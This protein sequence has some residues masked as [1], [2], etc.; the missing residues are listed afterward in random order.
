MRKQ[1]RS[2]QWS[3]FGAGALVIVALAW[4]FSSSASHPHFTPGR[5]EA[6]PTS[7]AILTSTRQP[8]PQTQNVSADEKTPE[9]APSETPLDPVFAAFEEWTE[10]YAAAPAD[11]KA[12]LEAAGVTLSA[13]RRDALL[14]LM[15]ADPRRAL[16]KSAPYRTRNLVPQSVLAKLEIPIHAKGTLG[17]AV[18]LQFDNIQHRRSMATINDTI[19]NAHLYGRRV[20][21]IANTPIPLHGIAIGNDVAIH[22]NPVRLL[23]A[24]EAAAVLAAN[25]TKRFCPISGREV[26][27]DDAAVA[28]SG[29]EYVYL[30]H[31]NH[32]NQLN[33]QT[34]A[35]EGGADATGS[36]PIAQSAWTT[37]TKTLLY[38]I[39]RFSDQ[40]AE[41]QSF[42]DATN[43]MNTVSAWF[44]EVSYGLTSMTPTITPCFVLPNDTAYYNTNGDGVLMSDARAVAK[45]NGFDYA[46]YNLD[47]IRWNGGPGSYG[48][49]AYVG[50]RGCWLKS[51][52][53]GVAEH[54]FGH[55]YGLWHANYWN[56]PNDTVIGPGSNVEYGDPFDVMG[57]A[58][59][60]AQHYNAYE[61]NRLDWIPIANV[62]TVTTN[63]TYRLHSFDSTFNAANQFAIKTKKDATRDYWVDFRQK[64]TSNKWQ[65]NGV[66]LHW[67]P[68]SASSGSLLLDTTPSSPDGKNDSGI[69]LGRTFSDYIADVHITPIGKGGTTPES[70]DV[71]INRGTWATDHVPTLS[72]SASS[73][74]VTTG[75]AVN[76]TAT[77]SDPD[78]DTLS[79]YWEFG[80]GNFGTNSPSASKSWG[81]AREYVVRCTASDMKG[82]TASAQVVI[83][84]GA[85]TVRRIT[86]TVRDSLGNPLADVRVHNGLATTDS[87][88]RFCFTATDGT[89]SLVSVA[90][91]AYTIAAIKPG[92]TFA[93][94]FT[95]P[96][97]GPATGIDF[98]A[99]EATYKITGK[100]TTD[101][102][103]ALGAALVSNGTVTEPTD[104]SGNFTLPGIK[105]GAYTLTATKPGYTLT[106][107]GFTNPVG[108]EYGDATAKNFTG[109][110]TTY[111]ISGEITGVPAGSAVTVTDGYR[112]TTSYKN[113]AKTLYNLFGVP[114]GTWTLRA[115]F[116]GTSFTP[117]NFTNPLTISASVTNKNFAADGTQAFAISGTVTDMGSPLSGVTVSSGTN[118]GTTDTNGQYFIAGLANGSYTLT[119]TKSGFS[120]TPA[121]RNI[122]VASANITGQNFATTNVDTPPT[123]ATAAS[124]TPNPVL[125]TTTNLSVLGAD[126]NGEAYLTYTWSTVGTPPGPVTFNIN[127]AHSARNAVATFTAGAYG[128]YTLR[129]TIK[130]YNGGTVTS[131]VN[132]N[133]IDPSSMPQVAFNAASSSGSESVTSVS[134][135]VS[136]SFASAQTVTVNYAVS[137]GSATGGGTDYTLASG[138]LSFAAGVTSK[139]ISFS[140]VNDALD[141][142]NETIQITLSSPTNSVLGANSNHT[143]TITDD[144]PTPTVAF[145]AANSSGAESATPTLLPV[146]LSAASGQTI[147]VNYAVTGGTATG[148]GTD[149]TLASGTLTFNAGTTTQNISLAVVNDALN[150]ADETVQ[151]TL[152]SPANATLG[153]NTVHTYTITD[154]DPQ[155]TVAFNAASSSGS[156]SVTAVTL[157][158]SLSAA[159]GR[160]VT[161]NYAVTGGTATGGGVDYTLASGTLTFNAGTT[162]QNISVA[163]VNDTAS[164]PSETI[165]VTL[166]SPSNATLGTNTVHTY[167]I[168]DNDT[169]VSFGAASSSGAESATAVN[170]PVSLS[171]ASS[172]T[173]SVNYA[174]TGGT[175]TG[176][177]TD[178]TLASGTLTFAPGTT[179]QN[180]ALSVNDDALNEANETVQI[181]LSSPVNASLG[182][183]SVHTYTIT[184]NDPAPNVAFNA[185]SSSGLENITAVSIPVSLN[186]ASGQSVTVA[187]A[188]TGGTATGGGVDYTLASGTLT[189]NAGTTT[190]NISVT[191]VNDTASEPSETIQI[192]LSSPTNATLGTNTVYTYTILDNDTTVAFGT[193][194]SSGSESA[195]AVNIPV[196]LSNA[197]SQTISVNYAVTGGTATGSGTDYTLASGTLTFAPGTATQNIA[198]AVVNDAL[199]ENDETI[200]L[201]L[202]S[203]TNAAL[204]AI[205]V[206]TY[207]ITDN[208]PTP[209]VGF[210][211]ASSSGLEN[212][213]AVNIP[214]SLSAAS[215]LSVSVAYAV[216]GGSATGGGTDY[217]LA[218]GTLTFAAGT[219]S[220]NI[221]VTIVNDAAVEPIETIQITLSAPVNATLGTATHIYSILND[222]NTAPVATNASFTTSKNVAVSG[223]LA[224]TDAEN[225]PLTFSIVANGALGTAVITNAATGAFTYTPKTGVR[226]TD[227][228]TF[229]ANDG[230]L[231]SNTA[232]VTVKINNGKPVASASQI[233]AISAAPASGSFTASD[234]DSDPLTYTVLSSGTLGTL[235][236][237]PATGAFT[238]T[239]QNNSGGEDQITFQVTDGQDVSNTATLTIKIPPPITFGSGPIIP[240][241]FVVNVPSVVTSGAGSNLTIVW[242]F[243]DGSTVSGDPAAHTYQ[244]A[245][246]YVLRVTASDA[247]G[248]KETREY[249][250]NVLGGGGAEPPIIVDT[251]GDGVSDSNE[252]SMGTDPFSAASVAKLPMTVSKI[253]GGSRPTSPGKDVCSLSGSIPD[254]GALSTLAGM[255]FKLN[256]AGA[257]VP[258]TLDAMGRAKN[259][260]GSLSLKLKPAKRN[261]KTKSISFLGGPLAFKAKITGDF[262][263]AWLAS[264]IDTTQSAKNAALPVTT[265]ITFNGA[266][267]TS[268]LN[269]LFTAVA[270]KGG[271]FKK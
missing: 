168:L 77:A 255:T 137:G 195:T 242:D 122:T 142:A 49:Q 82:G 151:V 156:E 240:G 144:D 133:V 12:E 178:Y 140:V 143:Y 39:V 40:P 84:V 164:E 58:G 53:A 236:V 147:S 66:E 221:A 176:G 112:T 97:T 120:F 38:I 138:T 25:K 269:T 148:G 20:N 98:T 187:Y 75:T 180:I 192:T 205:S 244:A 139:N 171:N 15:K 69:V 43:E 214:V 7:S 83:A 162:T 222:D 33:E 88:Y 141:E 68:Y 251:D 19:Y 266:I 110:G 271:K 73:T 24:D 35:Q 182:A 219:T 225:D 117:S 101:G 158:V 132:V 198:L 257:E 150:E 90:A 86:G 207:T 145:N 42:T 59:G 45:T 78:G 224:A 22:E 248:Q 104:S 174:V 54:E 265:D 13:Q 199:D 37:G 76:F 152:S 206:H 91:T 50:S 245:G 228:F 57:A 72:I 204:G 51:S 220:K 93:T 129:A 61:K 113:G 116:T 102:T 231:N 159:S 208:D 149:Y 223:T 252:L 118:S 52:S 30:C 100:V 96:I 114:A 32:L 95:N 183:T 201:T 21:Q 200:Q 29:S 31:S 172:Q 232:T 111:T 124:A 65:M 194:T 48:G 27:G 247:D 2:R 146:S 135:P 233:T 134:I 256:V 131:D 249:L 136:L 36:A 235:T 64:F 128:T 216:T 189:F 16:E 243:G 94:N 121:T 230:S 268:T 186:A 8:Q 267:Y 227:T 1:A 237:D 11:K 123:V 71:V 203:P 196:S 218:N 87:N 109:A 153:A 215:G 70:M 107:S 79:Y 41:P 62:T 6:Q 211:A 210:N 229:K 160:S 190:Q 253:A 188:V 179:T 170:I 56:A 105:N 181:T 55:N 26:S 23:D 155:P 5:P 18:A 260:H 3:R 167:T 163:I 85:P 226:G 92:W 197:S 80:D 108:V 184:D 154:N 261:S 9:A 157:P 119:P 169:L 103:T 217:T 126:N 34:I 241:T 67:N 262:A 254:I 173:I 239:V 166:S 4:L 234:P 250:I 44:N 263:A 63:G 165:Q 175:A 47:A 264:G 10:N 127:A 258:F 246:G 177:G 99:T 161:V 209:T 202:S 185:T 17:I 46:T 212:I 191:I 270:G 130:D 213:T 81:T 259:A 125:G 60:G 238:Y 193:A 74:S 14:T 106:P 28:Q 89:Y 115:S